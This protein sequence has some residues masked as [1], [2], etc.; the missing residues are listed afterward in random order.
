MLEDASLS[1]GALGWVLQKVLT[2]RCQV[3][4]AQSLLLLELILSVGK[5]T[6][7]LLLRVLALL[8]KKPEAAELGLDLLFP[9]VF[10]VVTDQIAV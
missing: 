10:E 5:A 3:L 7:L 4:L 9:C 8:T 6:A 1:V 2:D